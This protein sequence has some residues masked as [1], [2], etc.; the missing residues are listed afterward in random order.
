MLGRSHW[1]SKR[2][3]GKLKSDRPITKKKQLVLSEQKLCC[4][5]GIEGCR[6]GTLLECLTRDKRNIF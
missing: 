3:T 6:L 1:L 5:H 2:I 4:F